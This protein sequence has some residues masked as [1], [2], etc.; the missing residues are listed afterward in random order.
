MLNSL[1]WRCLGLEQVLV[2]DELYLYKAIVQKGDLLQVSFYNITY[3]NY[4]EI[5]AK[6]NPAK[7]WFILGHSENWTRD[8]SHPKRESYH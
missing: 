8:L 2:F 4:E 7:T 1:S 6:K 3:A 5:D